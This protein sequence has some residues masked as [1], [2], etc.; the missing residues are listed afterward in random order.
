HI[1]D[2]ILGQFTGIFRLFCIVWLFRL[3]C[4]VWI[5]RLFH[6]AWIFWFFRITSFRFLKAFQERNISPVA[7]A[8]VLY[9]KSTLCI[10]FCYFKPDCINSLYFLCIHNLI[11][12]RAVSGSASYR[13]DELISGCVVRD[14]IW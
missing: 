2:L 1:L 9:H 14:I 3:L 5:F 6:V 8:V 12:I 10:F 11:S 13:K 7:I 4:I